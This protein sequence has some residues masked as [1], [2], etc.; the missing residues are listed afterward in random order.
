MQLY[1]STTAQSSNVADSSAYDLTKPY[2]EFAGVLSNVLTWDA[3]ALVT[4]ASL[5]AS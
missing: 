1:N 3:A 2:A 4:E 5:M